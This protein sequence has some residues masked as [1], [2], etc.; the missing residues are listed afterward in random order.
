MKTSEISKLEKYLIN[1]IRI[2]WFVWD[3]GVVLFDSQ[4]DV[5]SGKNLGFCL[6]FRF[7]RGKLGPNMDQNHHLWVRLISA[8]TL[9]FERMFRDCLYLIKDVPLVEVSANSSHIWIR[10]GPETHQKGPIH[11]CCITMK[12]FENW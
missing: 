1:L 3:L 2:L 8:K 12:T 4:K 9:I 11:R 7:S 5:V 6:Y 10:K